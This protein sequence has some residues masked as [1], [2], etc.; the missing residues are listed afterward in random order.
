MT[1]HKT[2]KEL[3]LPEAL[4][5]KRR[6]AADE[7]FSFGCHAQ[8]PCFTDCCADV[9]I[10]LTPV[11][12]LRLARHLGLPT[13]Q[14][15]DEHAL[16]PVT[17]E[18]HLPAVVLKMSA[19]AD[20]RG[21]FVGEAGCTVYEHR[22]WACRMYPV[23]SALPPARAGVQPEPV[24]VLLEDA[25]CKGHG[26]TRQWTVAGWRADQGVEAQEELEAG[27][28]E[29]V[30]HP[31][32]IGGRQLNPKQM[33]LFFT[34]C[35]DLDAFRRF[36]F[37][38]TFLARFD[39]PAALVEQLRQDDEALLRFAFRWLRFALFGEQTLTVREGARAAAE[40]RR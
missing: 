11:D 7:R 2:E 29:I 23:A 12:V 24:Y 38:S 27:F 17:K 18:L 31:W 9:N 36:V 3:E 6:L 10:I 4:R 25:F 37:E 39:V 28:R 14:F 8:L 32:F 15:L 19:G 13:K 5:G 20:K 34:A 26:E 1:E 40:Q 35:Y 22:P 30:A 16:L 21:P 33:E